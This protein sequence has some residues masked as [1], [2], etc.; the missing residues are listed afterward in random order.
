MIGS[1]LLDETVKTKNITNPSLVLK[2]MQLQ[3]AHSLQQTVT[4]N[5]DGMDMAIVA[6]NK[7]QRKI[8][9]AGAKN[10][11]FLIQG[12]NEY[13][14]KGDRMSIGGKQLFSEEFTTHEFD[15]I[16]G[17]KIYLFS[18]GYQDQFGGQH[19]DKFMRKNLKELISKNAHLPMS[20]QKQILSNTLE[21]WRSGHNQIDDILVMG[22]QL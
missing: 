11:V 6:L 22:F 9:V 14:V 4:N 16:E 1:T 2:E 7:K 13:W 10:P 3:V 19:G 15:W 20:D 8:Y 18:D 12:E 5:R 17:T 21:N